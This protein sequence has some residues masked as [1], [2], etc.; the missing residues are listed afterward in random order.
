MVKPKLLLLDC[1][2]A[3]MSQLPATWY[4]PCCRPVE[5]AVQPYGSSASVPAVVFVSPEERLI[6]D[7]L[8]PPQR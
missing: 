6:A 2:V 7:G 4:N 8:P 5:A 1:W 3:S